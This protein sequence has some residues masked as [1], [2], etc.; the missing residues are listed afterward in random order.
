MPIF[1]ML[2]LIPL[3]AGAAVEYMLCRYPKRRFWRV[4]PPVAAVLAVAV[5]ALTRYHGWDDAGAGAPVETL[6][7]FPGLPALGL[8]V[9]LFLGWRAWKYLWRPRVFQER[10][11]KQ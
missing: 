5:V 8:F 6:L 4:L 2:F 9:G 3:A 7:F 10:K 1:V 11:R